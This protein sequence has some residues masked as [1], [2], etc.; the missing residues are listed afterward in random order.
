[1]WP[2]V[3]EDVRKYVQSC[4]ECHKVA[5]R[6]AKAPLI[7]IPVVGLQFQRIAKDVVGPLLTTASG[8]QYIL[9]IVTMLL[10]T[11]QPIPYEPLQ[12]Q[13]W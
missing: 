9:V 6:I 10:V 8:N 5:K 11:L 13:R 3:A 4:P 7:P 1:M 12:H 2:G